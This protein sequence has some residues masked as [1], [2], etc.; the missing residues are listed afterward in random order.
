MIEKK[1]PNKPKTKQ[2]SNTK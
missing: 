2:P 1:T